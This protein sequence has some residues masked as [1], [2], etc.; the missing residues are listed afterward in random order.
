M[1][2]PTLPG[3][4]PPHRGPDAPALPG[5]INHVDQGPDDPAFLLECELLQ[6]LGQQ[7]AGVLALLERQGVLLRVLE[8][9]W[10][11]WTARRCMRGNTLYLARFILGAPPHLVVTMKN[12]DSLDCRRDNLLLTRA[13]SAPTQT[14]L[15]EDNR[16]GDCGIGWYPKLGC[17]RARGYDHGKQVHLG[18][19]AP[20]EEAAQA[21]QAYRRTRSS[22]R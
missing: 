11:R 22:S 20:V 5:D 14:R 3:C 10:G 13:P 4:P 19:V 8:D 7:G 12:G 15:R 6:P 21:A 1:V 17:W 16:S 18:Y 2:R 9:R